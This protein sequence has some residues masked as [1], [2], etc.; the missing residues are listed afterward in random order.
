MGRRLKMATAHV[1]QPPSD[2]ILHRS[3][4][5]LRVARLRLKSAGDISPDILADGAGEF[6]AVPGNWGKDML[7]Q[8][9]PFPPCR[10]RDLRSH[11]GTDMG[12]IVK[13]VKKPHLLRLSS[14]SAGAA[15]HSTSGSGAKRS[16]HA[17]ERSRVS[18]ALA[19]FISVQSTARSSSSTP[20]Q[21]P[22][23]T[24]T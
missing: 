14:N 11:S 24:T 20:A 12:G 17:R 21:P 10:G 5:P 8:Q 9:C 7:Q 1:L 16:N 2:A 3:G 13:V 15:G 4:Q 6:Q 22:D 23:A 18:R 19:K